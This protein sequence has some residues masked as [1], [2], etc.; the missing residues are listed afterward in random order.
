MRW[1][2]ALALLLGAAPAADATTDF[3]TVAYHDV[4]DAPGDLEADAVTIQS[5]AAQFDWLRDQ[6]YRVISV[7]DVLAAHRGERPLPPRAVLLSFDDGYASHYTRVFPLLQAFN[8]PAVF[9]IAGSWV[10]PPEGTRL[11]DVAGGPPRSSNHQ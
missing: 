2:L 5:L 10:E 9:A 1:L 8:Y 6:G 4:K 3:V 7:D 11:G